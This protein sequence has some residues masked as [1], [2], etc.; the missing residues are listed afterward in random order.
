MTV[1]PGHNP[2]DPLKPGRH[3]AP[4][5]IRRVHYVAAR[6]AGHS[7]SESLR[8]AGFRTVTG[9]TRWRIENDPE[10]N[11]QIAD[12]IARATAGLATAPSPDQPRGPGRPERP[13]TALPTA[14]AAAPATAAPAP[15]TTPSDDGEP[16][17]SQPPPLP[18]NWGW[19]YVD[20][21]HTAGR[22]L[23]F[24]HRGTR[25]K[26]PPALGPAQ[27]PIYTR[28]RPKVNDTRGR[29]LRRSDGVRREDV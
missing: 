23:Q 1:Y 13:L 22:I 16:A 14:P 11:R 3:L 17:S 12:G 27:E 28:A 24:S 25:L 8:H 15:A 29:I 4:A 26:S 18:S 6:I 21:V 20:D 5:A 9:G 2:R 10:L 19:P 7:I